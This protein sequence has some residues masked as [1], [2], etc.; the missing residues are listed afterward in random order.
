MKQL[1]RWTLSKDKFKPEGI[2]V[3]SLKSGSAVVVQVLNRYST[4]CI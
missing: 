2:T 3:I 1:E 4:R